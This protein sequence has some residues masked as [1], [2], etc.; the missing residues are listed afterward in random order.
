[1]KSLNQVTGAP[2]R[3]FELRFSGSGLWDTAPSEVLMDS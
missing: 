1:M 3:E 2:R